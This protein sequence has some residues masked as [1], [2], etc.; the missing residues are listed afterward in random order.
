MG[1][2]AKVS[3]NTRN[4]KSL[5]Y[6]SDKCNMLLIKGI[7]K[8]INCFDVTLSTAVIVLGSSADLLSLLPGV[9]CPCVPVETKCLMKV[10]LLKIGAFMQFNSNVLYKY[11]QLNKGEEMLE[12]FVRKMLFINYTHWNAFFRLKKEIRI[13][14][15][16]FHL[17]YISYEVNST[18]FTAENSCVLW[19]GAISCSN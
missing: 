13:S 4:M 6:F 18:I 11:L 16:Q 19:C 12:I 5:V 2:S 9:S 7:C 10:S 15:A 1:L 17:L 3:R 14:S 8:I